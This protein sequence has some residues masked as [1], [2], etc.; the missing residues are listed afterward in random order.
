MVAVTDGDAPSVRVRVEVLLLVKNVC[1]D[2]GVSLGLAVSVVVVLAV[3]VGVQ[4]GLAPYVRLR[5]GV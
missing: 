3:R 2:D 4:E 1:V 5:V